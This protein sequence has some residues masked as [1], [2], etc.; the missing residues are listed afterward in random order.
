MPPVAVTLIAVVVQVN[1][2]VPLLLV[3]PAVVASMV[4]FTFV[5]VL[6]QALVTVIA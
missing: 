5:E 3:I 6:P 2:V 4:M 1:T